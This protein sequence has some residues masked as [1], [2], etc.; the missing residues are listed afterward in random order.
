MSIS[1]LPLAKIFQPFVNAPL[2]LINS[3]VSWG[4]NHDLGYNWRLAHN[5]RLFDAYL[6]FRRR[7]SELQLFFLLKNNSCHQLLQSKFRP[8]M[9]KHPLLA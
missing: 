9:S 5:Y 1:P 4:V 7:I 2:F 6:D 8:A 3:Y